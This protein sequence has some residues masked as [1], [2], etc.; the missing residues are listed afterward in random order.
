MKL[1]VKF[2]VGLM[3]VFVGI[4]LIPVT[5]ENPPI[6]SDFSGPETVHR[7]LKRSCYDCHSYETQWPWYSYVAPVSWLV[8]HDVNEGRSELNF[9]QWQSLQDPQ[10]MKEEI[11][12]EIEEGEMPLPNYI[13]THKQARVSPEEIA[14]LRKWAGLTAAPSFHHEDHN[15]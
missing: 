2:C 6:E 1:Y 5:R 15:D 14:L 8:A 9:S 3:V 11:V 12:E 10:A 4:Q 7:I 13:I